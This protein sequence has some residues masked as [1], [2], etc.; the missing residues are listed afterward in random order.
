M[1]LPTVEQVDEAVPVGGEP[2]R[3]LV[4]AVLKAILES[5]SWLPGDDTI[6]VRTRENDVFT[7]GRIKANAA[8]DPEDCVIMQQ[9]LVR[10]G[11]APANPTSDGVNGEF[12]IDGGY[13]YICVS[14]NNWVRIPVEA[15]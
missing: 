1:A 10:G 7:G 9:T 5:A 14:L 6:P 13:L 11:E 4:N 2:S 15:W 3:A 8:M 12:V